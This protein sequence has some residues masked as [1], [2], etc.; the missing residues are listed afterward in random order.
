MEIRAAVLYGAHQPFTIENLDLQPP[1][2]GEVLVKVRAVGVCHSDWHIVSGATSHPMPVVPGHEGAGIVEAVG[3]GVTT[4]EVG[5]HVSLNWAPSCGSCFYCL[6]SQPNLCSSYVAA[7]WA[8]TMLDRTTRLS[9]DGRPVFH[10]SALACFAERTVVP[11]Q[12]CIPLP[13]NVPFAVSALIGCA[14]TTGVGAVLNTAKVPPESSVVVFGVG[15]VGL[16]I[17]MGAKLA[18]ASSIIAVDRSDEKLKTALV[19]GATH[20]LVSDDTDVSRIQALTD[21]RGADYVFEAVGIP[22]VQEKCLY[23]ARPGGVV[24]LAGIS[25]MGSATNLPGAVL[26]RQEKTVMGSYYGSSNPVVDFPKYA[27]FYTQGLLDLDRLIT[28]TYSLDQINEAYADLLSGKVARGV[29]VF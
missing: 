14:V 13:K 24:V 5:D 1:Q 19:F 27:E 28:K 2:E 18:G 22:E 3:P 11:Q 21:G 7:V 10:F 26:T 9:K 20:G 16:S 4:I 17:V 25:P 8:G 12:C 15:G 6:H 23:G 29:I